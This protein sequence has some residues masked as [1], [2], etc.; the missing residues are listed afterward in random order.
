MSIVIN[1]IV[2]G[3]TFV[4]QD[5]NFIEIIE[6]NIE[7]TWQSPKG[8]LLYNTITPN[9]QIKASRSS[10][11]KFSEKMSELNVINNSELA[12]RYDEIIEQTGKQ[13]QS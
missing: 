2:K 7:K 4:D 13:M 9:G 10:I 8:N 3:A 12:K 1:N 11:Q 6:S 5:N